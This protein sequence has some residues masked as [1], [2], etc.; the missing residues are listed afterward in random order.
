MKANTIKS[1]GHKGLFAVLIAVCAAIVLGAGVYGFF[2]LKAL[3]EERCVITDM[4]GQIEITAGKMV[5]PDIIAESL[6]L[7]KGVNLAH[8]DFVRRRDEILR[9]IP[10]LRAVSITRMPPGRLRIVA[11]EREPVAR[12]GVRGQRRVTGRVV[13]TE[14]MVFL[15][16][17]GTYHLPTISEPR[18]P[19]TRIGHRISGRAFAALQLIEACQRPEFLELGVQDVDISR[20]D[21][22]LATLGD[23]SRLKIAWEGM[24]DAPTA[25]SREILR[26]RLEQLVTTIRSRV[27]VGAKMWNA[28]VSDY[29]YADTQGDR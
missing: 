7:R 24:D 14:G 16:Q 23:Y 20:P 2:R 12:M 8:V 10:T 18:A 21:Y 13:D 4:A 22:L 3:Y 15:C 5:K 25:K 11:E 29:I 9:K 6:G 28:T 27:G 1:G 19:G 17:R 26:V